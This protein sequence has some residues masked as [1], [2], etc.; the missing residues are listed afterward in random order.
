MAGLQSPI[1]KF[2]PDEVTHAVLQRV[3]AEDG[4]IVFFGADTRKV[5]N[6]ALGALPTNLVR[7]WG[8]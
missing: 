1:L 5:V 3:G 7:T 6:D 2:I 8:L 4:D